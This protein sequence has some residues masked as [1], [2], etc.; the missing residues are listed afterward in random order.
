MDNLEECGARPLFGSIS[1]FNEL[2]PSDSSAECELIISHLEHFDDELDVFASL[3][4]ACEFLK[5]LEGRKINHIWRYKGVLEKLLLWCFHIRRKFL[6]DLTDEDIIEFQL[7]YLYPPSNWVSG[8][9]HKRFED[10]FGYSNFNESWRPFSCR[11]DFSSRK[12]GMSSAL[13][14]ILKDI[15]LR[16]NPRAHF[17]ED[18]ANSAEGLQYSFQSVVSMQ[19][20]YLEYLYSQHSA[21]GAYEIKLFMYACCSFM[22]INCNEFVKLKSYLYL[23]LISVL[24]AGGFCWEIDSN[25]GLLT[26]TLPE[27]FRKYYD[28]Y[29]ESVGIDIHLPLVSKKL[30]F[31]HTKKK[32]EVT[33]K[34]LYV[35]FQSL[36]RHPDIPLSPKNILK[37]L[38]LDN[39]SVVAKALSAKDVRKLNNRINAQKKYQQFL[40]RLNGMEINSFGDSGLPNSLVSGYRVRPLLSLSTPDGEIVIHTNQFGVINL[41]RST[42]GYMVSAHLGSLLILFMYTSKHLAGGKISD[43]VLSYEILILWSFLVRRKPVCLLTEKDADEFF[44]FC[45][46][47]PS[48]WVSKC[49]FRILRN[50]DLSFPKYD[51]RWR[52]F[53]PHRGSPRARAAKIITLCSIVQDWSINVGIS[54]SNAFSKLR[55]WLWTGYE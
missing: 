6:L 37:I 55:R 15:L 5:G 41:L 10:V 12:K 38:A 28:R 46:D 16:K 25:C 29:C 7:F 35:W 23:D 50:C 51:P 17:L 40:G 26:Y 48:S 1:S 8:R 36:P 27:E 24:P 9:C 21:R 54:N 19:D 44:E 14:R 53:R 34:T 18:D 49:S 39:D 43:A 2:K 20:K 42:S 13:F 4:I 22:R 30:L 47:P 3:S 33:A 32:T 52:P 11:N 31:S 45:C